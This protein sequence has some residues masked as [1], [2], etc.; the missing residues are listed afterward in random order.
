M[1]SEIDVGER[2]VALPQG[3][4]HGPVSESFEGDR[5]HELLSG[6]REHDVHAGAHFGEPPGDGASL[7][8]GDS[9]GHAENDAPAC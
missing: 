1:L 7:I 4:E 8:A 9:A 5:T 3:G 2:G 6:C